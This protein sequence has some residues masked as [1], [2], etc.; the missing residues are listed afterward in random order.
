MHP[1]RC[2]ESRIYNA[3]ILHKADELA[4]RQLAVS[5]V[6][7]REWSRYLLDDDCSPERARAVLRINERIFR[8]CLR[9]M[10][11]RAVELD[12]AYRPLLCWDILLCNAN[13][14]AGDPS[15]VPLRDAGAPARAAATST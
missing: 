9:D 15:A 12:Q 11:F 3:Q 14:S 10:H 1:E 7:A 6:C 13:A 4:M 5:V 2:M 8:K